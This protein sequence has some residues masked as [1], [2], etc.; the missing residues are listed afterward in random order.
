M[1]TNLTSCEASSREDLELPPAFMS[2]VWDNA[3]RF[4]FRLTTRHSPANHDTKLGLSFESVNIKEA[5]SSSSYGKPTYNTDERH[6]PKI[7][8][9]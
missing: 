8:I 9:I 3:S 2:S 7:N 1:K 4:R 5:R 6:M